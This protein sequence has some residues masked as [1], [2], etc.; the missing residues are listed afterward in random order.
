MKKTSSKNLTSEEMWMPQWCMTLL[1]TCCVP[2]GYSSQLTRVFLLNLKVRLSG[3]KAV[4]QVFTSGSWR[5][6]CSDDWK[7][8]YGNTTCKHLGFSRYEHKM[9]E[10]LFGI[11]NK[12]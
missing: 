11:L 8:E 3:K 10:T 2:G 4:L 9:E 7:A 6:V 1:C 5:T 12:L